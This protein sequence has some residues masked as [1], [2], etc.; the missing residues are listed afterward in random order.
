M[1]P[2]IAF[3][4]CASVVFYLWYVW[5]YWP[6]NVLSRLEERNVLAEQRAS[7][8]RYVALEHAAMAHWEKLC[9]CP[10]L[11]RA[12]LEMRQSGRLRTCQYVARSPFGKMPNYCSDFED[13][14][15]LT[16]AADGRDTRP[17]A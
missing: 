15:V 1:I 17:H 16:Y 2:V 8:R 9:N 4:V 7:R 14:L 3:L 11:T 12:A 10:D 13:W 6:G 5:A